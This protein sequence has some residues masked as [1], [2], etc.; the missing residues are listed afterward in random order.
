MPAGALMHPNRKFHI[1]DR[2]E[3][4]ALVREAGF[5]TL[6]VQTGAGLRAVHVPVVLDGER[7]LFH[8]SR[9][10]LVHAALLGGCEA[11]FIAN[12]PH[13]Y[14]S[15]D[16]YG[17]ENRVPTWSYVAVELNGRCSPLDAAVLV[18]LLDDMSAEHEARLAPKAP[19]VRGGLSPGF[20]EGLLKGITG[21]AMEIAQ[22][23]GTKKI[24]QDKPADVR[25]RLA[26][27]LAEQGE[28]EMAHLVSSP[29]QD[30][31]GGHA[32]HGGGVEGAGVRVLAPDTQDLSQL[33]LHQP[34]AGPPPHALH[35]EDL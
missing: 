31:E 35:G 7:L 34:S 27:A 11:L 23:R 26:D 5:G 12:G 1:A 29:S 24:D 21:F 13:A 9:G 18:R 33:P 25:A 20:F 32:K 6:V 2:A 22:W 28:A 15:P 4:A 14:I 8:V 17:L 3:M 19:W 16:W 10:N 30:G